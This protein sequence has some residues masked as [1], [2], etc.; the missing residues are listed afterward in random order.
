MHVN[1]S[2]W[3]VPSYEQLIFN[4][5]SSDYCVVIPVID[6]GDRI[7]LFLERMME[8]QIFS[9]ADIIIVDGGSVD[10]SLDPVLLEEYNVSALLIKT[11]PGRLSAQLRC[12]YSFALAKGYHGIITI[13]G[14]NKDD[15]KDIPDFISALANGADFVQ[16]SRFIKGG[17]SE[18]TPLLRTLAIKLIHAPLL[19]V[20]SGYKWTDTTQG[21]R[22]Y[23]KR[24]LCDKNIAVFRAV[25]VD[26]ELLFYLSYMAPRLNYACC[27]LPTSRIYPKG[28]V[29][30]KIAGIFAVCSLLAS[31][32]K[33]CRGA[34]NVRVCDD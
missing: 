25:F 5:P 33:V 16:G 23:S 12:A 32:S 18:N 17:N 14:N 7:K 1:S 31:L 8:L 21:F 9:M 30:T 19:R 29:P 3:E 20:T 24:L 11:G 27:E 13:D 34:Y 2:T 15:P 4:Q 22:G 10:S 28:K 26:Y 6:E